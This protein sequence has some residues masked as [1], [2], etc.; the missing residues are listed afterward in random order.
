MLRVLLASKASLV[1]Q[2][3][4]FSCLLLLEGA[5]NE[6]L[7]RNLFVLLGLQ[8]FSNMFCGLRLELISSI[9]AT[10]LLPVTLLMSLVFVECLYLI[11][12]RT[13]F[14][15][16]HG[17]VSTKLELI[18]FFFASTL[19]NFVNFRA[20]CLKPREA[21]LIR[22]ARPLALLA[23]ILLVVWGG[24]PENGLVWWVSI[25]FGLPSIVSFSRVLKSDSIGQLRWRKDYFVLNFVFSLLYLML[26][27][28]LIAAIVE[29]DKF[30][31]V[32]VFYRILTVTTTALASN[33]RAIHLFTEGAR[34]GGGWV[35]LAP[36]SVL[37]VMSIFVVMVEQAALSY[38]LLLLI[39]VFLCFGR[40][41]FS[42]VSSELMKRQNMH[43]LI[44]STVLVAK[45][46][47]FLFQ[48]FLSWKIVA[49]API[50]LS[51]LA[52]LCISTSAKEGV[53]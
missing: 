26:D 10:F 18:F 4:A 5:V 42:I 33:H 49:V 24:L 35:V 37:A 40:L 6:D 19:W 16:L 53:K 13:A 48:G 36:A 8:R 22:I 30:I 17:S 15:L 1:A 7:L 28:Y 20:A 34:L 38:W 3:L 41:Y 47:Y 21:L 29:N 23:F 2:V 46:N 50:L 51:L 12:Q 11:D 31:Q 39:I 27:L 52:L 32:F 25:S 43:Y 9:S 45:L 14:N 44:L